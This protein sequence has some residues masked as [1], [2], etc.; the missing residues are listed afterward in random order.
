MS[1]LRPAPACLALLFGVVAGVRAQTTDSPFLPAGGAAPVTATDNASLELRGLLVEPTGPLFHLVDL[2]T[3]KGAW[4]G[5]RET[6]HE[7]V[8][9][10]YQAQPEGD[11]I[12]VDY[13]GRTLQLTLA[14]GKVGTAVAAA[15]PA[16]TPPGILTPPPNGPISPVVLN[17]TAADE[18]RRMEA[19]AAELRRR[20]EQRQLERQKALANPPPPAPPPGN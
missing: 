9:T 8:V 2:A 14:K 15:A 3:K 4:I 11:R 6:G 17:P 12:T 10:S 16:V 20:R 7:F 13:R 19:V 1:P 5:L 18:A